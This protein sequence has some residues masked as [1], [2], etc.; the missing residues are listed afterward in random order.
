MFKY[1]TFTTR[2]YMSKKG[3]ETQPGLPRGSLTRS[4]LHIKVLNLL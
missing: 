3:P 4:F 2:I 1:L